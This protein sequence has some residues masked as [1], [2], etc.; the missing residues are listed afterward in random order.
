MTDKKPYWAE[1]MIKNCIEAERI[2]TY[3]ETPTMWLQHGNNVFRVRRWPS[4]RYE[5]MDVAN[6]PCKDLSAFNFGAFVEFFWNA[7]SI[8][9][10]QVDNNNGMDLKRERTK[11]EDVQ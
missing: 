4:G 6:G 7:G 3:Y 9:G 5:V 10:F 11:Q 8:S 1:D 2:E